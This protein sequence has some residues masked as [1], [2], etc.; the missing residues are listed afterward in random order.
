MSHVNE[1]A[2]HAYLDG[3][4]SELPSG[5][6]RAIREHVATCPECAMRLEEEKQIREEAV[7]I[8]SGALPQVEFPPLE[9]LRLRAAATSL[10][11]GPRSGR[12]HRLGWAASVVLAVGTGWMLRGGPSIR[13]DRIDPLERPTPP[14]VLEALPIERE[15]PTP[16]ASERE[17]LSRALDQSGRSSDLVAF[18]RPGETMASP[19]VSAAEAVAAPERSRS[20]LS[21]ADAP[22]LDA[23]L[24][25]GFQEVAAADAVALQDRL[26][27]V[28]APPALEPSK[29][30]ELPSSAA[31]ARRFEQALSAPSAVVLRSV[32]VD[33]EEE[34]AQSNA[35]E[36]TV[37][38]SARRSGAGASFQN[39]YSSERQ[40]ERQDSGQRSGWECSCS[41]IR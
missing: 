21:E 26:E 36:R 6:A 14:R 10:P 20:D 7:A 27:A 9:E 38:T 35:S 29:L 22:F 17:L 23:D 34:R 5:D 4:L 8:L 15:A 18:P 31:T 2:L 11:T 37:V 28:P 19:V 41:P 33:V 12:L 16:D 25:A 30:V 13:F 1:G 39:S 40:R 3:A 24:R 32:N